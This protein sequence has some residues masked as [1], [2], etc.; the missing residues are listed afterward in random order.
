M[1]ELASGRECGSEGV[2][3]QLGEKAKIPRSPVDWG[4]TS[5]RSLSS[6]QDQPPS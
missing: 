1:F 2:L 5:C 6:T 3:H 4:R